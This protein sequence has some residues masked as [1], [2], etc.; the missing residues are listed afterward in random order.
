MPRSAGLRVTSGA[1][2]R[3]RILVLAAAL[4]LLMFACA[5]VV[6]L[7]PTGDVHAARLINDAPLVNTPT[8]TPDAGPPTVTATPT[9]TR[10]SR[11][12]TPTP[13]PTTGTI[14]TKT[15]TA[16]PVPAN[17][18]GGG[19]GAGTGGGSPSGPQPTKVVLSQPTIGASDSGPLGGLGAA[20]NGANGVWIA[21]LFGCITAILG[22]LVAAIALSVLVRGGY[23]P[24]LRALALGSRAKQRMK[25]SSGKGVSTQTGMQ[26]RL[27]QGGGWDESPPT[28]GRARDYDDELPRR[29]PG[30]RWQ[31]SQQYENY[32]SA[33]VWQ[34][35]DDRRPPPS[36]PRTVPRTGRRS[37][38]NW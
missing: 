23:G 33:R 15:P 12:P 28:F 2:R 24:F 29:G 34:A 16:T 5:A 13:T 7:T 21:S 30:G 20:T 19:G 14:A 22:I 11:K 8:V 3:R 38:A 37:R 35:R 25:G 10:T 18:G 36:N 31:D 27:R 6:Q 26:N 17:N 32:D 4:G 1:G 9:A